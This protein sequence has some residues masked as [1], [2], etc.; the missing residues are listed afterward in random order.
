MKIV[1][2]SIMLSFLILGTGCAVKNADAKKRKS[3]GAASQPASLKESQ[4]IKFDA[5]KGGYAILA[6][7]C[8]WCTEGVM[9]KLPGVLSAVSGYTGGKTANPTYADVAA[10]QTDQREAVF[11]T[12]DPKK[13]SYEQVLDAFWKSI[14]PTQSDGQF[15]DRGQQYTTAIYYISDKQRKIAEETKQKLEASKKFSKP[16]VTEILKA[17]SFWRAEEYHQDY[18]KKKPFKYRQYF[19]GSGRKR[20]IDK[21]WGKDT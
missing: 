8:F 20:F 16:I 1:I 14:D 2:H 19:I 15:A 5:N 12:F 9:E 3:K 6:G 21:T 7:G 17:N 11:V 10:G 18:Y 4:E 13:I